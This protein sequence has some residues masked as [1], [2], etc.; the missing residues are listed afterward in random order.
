MRNF[1][2]AA[3]VVSGAAANTAVPTPTDDSTSFHPILSKSETTLFSLNSSLLLLLL[4]ISAIAS[5]SCLWSIT[6]ATRA[7]PFDANSFR[8]WLIDVGAYGPRSRLNAVIAMIAS[9]FITTN[10]VFILSFSILK[11]LAHP[12]VS[13]RDWLAAD[14][15]RELHAAQTFWVHLIAATSSFVLRTAFF[16]ISKFMLFGARL[17]ATSEPMSFVSWYLF[18]VLLRSLWFAS[19]AERVASGRFPHSC[20]Q[21]RKLSDWAAQALAATLPEKQRLLEL[22][23]ICLL[24]L[25]APAERPGD[26]DARH[27][28][29]GIVVSEAIIFLGGCSHPYHYGCL[30]S[31]ERT[32]WGGAIR[33]GPPPPLESP[34]KVSACC[35]AEPRARLSR[36]ARELAPWMTSF[37]HKATAFISSCPLCRQARLGLVLDA[38]AYPAA[39]ALESTPY[40]KVTRTT[41]RRTSTTVAAAAS[42]VAP[43]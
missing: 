36:P 18:V 29:A 35:F 11:S 10:V 16:W 15:G 25:S 20:V 27:K 14:G 39:P 43:S 13:H 26:G 31:W 5:E 22:C 34:R 9:V 32:K 38:G 21:P 37:A 7:G 6:A 40:L 19:V 2:L 41:P 30:E 1:L 23:A 4:A 42:A 17:H 24:P 33:R 12:H 3:L 28:S 8:D